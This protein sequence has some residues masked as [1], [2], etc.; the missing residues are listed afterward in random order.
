MLEEYLAEDDYD[1]QQAIIKE[2]AEIKK[3]TIHSIRAKLV[4]QGIYKKKP[5]RITRAS[6]QSVLD[7]LVS[8]HKLELTDTEEEYMLR[9][10][11]NL[12]RKI[13]DIGE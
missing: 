4:S 3:V 2:W 8:K 11:V 13:H 10:T 1:E 6:K 7:V 12:L 5:K 9:L